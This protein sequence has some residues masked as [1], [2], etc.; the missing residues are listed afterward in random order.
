MRMPGVN[1]GS[2]LPDLLC[3]ARA[4]NWSVTFRTRAVSDYER[5]AGGAPDHRQRTAGT[6]RNKKRAPAVRGIYARMAVRNCLTLSG[7]LTFD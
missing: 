6:Y 5:H 4:V 2:R 3:G 1:S 7:I